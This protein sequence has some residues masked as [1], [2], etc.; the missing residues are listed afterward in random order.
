MC[1]MLL[2][3]SGNITP[4][5]WILPGLHVE[6]DQEVGIPERVAY[7]IYS[8]RRALEDGSTLHFPLSRLLTGHIASKK[9][10]AGL[11]V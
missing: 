10:R 5:P 4:L 1:P 9:L 3:V 2:A 8:T 6:A 7:S 11:E